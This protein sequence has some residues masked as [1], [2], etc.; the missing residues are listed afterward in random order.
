MLT[1]E[2][3][4]V[5]TEI[6]MGQIADTNAQILGRLFPE[7]GIRHVHRQTVGDNLERLAAA[8]KLALSRSDIVF[9]IGGLGPT[10]DDMTRD[11]IAAALDDP[12]VVDSAIEEKLRKMW[13]TRKLTWTDSQLR[14]AM[15]PSCGTPIDNPNGSAPGLLCEQDGKRIIALPGPKGEFGPMVEGPVQDILAKLS[16]D[17]IIHSR[18]LKVCGIGESIVEQKIKQLLNSENPTVAPYAKVG[19]V[20]LRVTARAATLGDAEK[21]ILPVEAQIREALGDAVF[22]VDSVTLEQAVVGL[23]IAKGKTLSV[24]ESMTG[25]G[26]GRRITSVPGASA[27]FLG[28]VIS[29]SKAAKIELLGIGRSLLDSPEIGPVSSEVAVAMAEGVRRT[30]KSDY[31]VSVTGN[32]GPTSDSGEKPVGLVY[33]AVAGPA[34]TT[35]EE[36]RYRGIREDVRDRSTQYALFQV[37]MALLAE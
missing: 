6:L 29:Y 35:F 9:T 12:L 11:G 32:A 37:R 22:G 18:L 26:L 19:E 10:L 3:V 27:V 24:A 21:L 14:Q 4:S 8:L 17:E 13:A 33:A 28:G 1:A 25:G 34:G 31:G 16:G 23:L 7:L 30:L 15:R 5:G 20:H 2:I 36:Y